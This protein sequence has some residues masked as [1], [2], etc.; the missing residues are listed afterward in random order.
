[1]GAVKTDLRH[2]HCVADVGG[3]AQKSLRDLYE[4]YEFA[5]RVEGAR[6]VLALGGDGF[7]LDV[8]HRYMSYGV[9]IYGMNCGTVGFLM[10]SYRL[11]RLDAALR[12]SEPV[13]LF[14]LRMRAVTT[15]GREYDA[16]AVN[17]VSLLRETRQ[18][19]HIRLS[20]DKRVRVQ[21]L[22][23]DGALICT[24]AGSTAYNLS[25]GGPI[26]PLGSG[27]LALTPLNPFRP[28]RWSGALIP[29]KATVELEVLDPAKRPVS[30]VADF[31]EIRDVARVEVACDEAHAVTLLFD[32]G[33]SLEE[34]IL[35]EQFL[36]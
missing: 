5:E 23:G 8:L 18:T 29:D 19:A 28:R 20:I 9:P 4:R 12:E 36:H 34:R 7:M 11:T 10:N 13:R 30:A 3:R 35:N 21:E 6:V 32:K 2:V 14:P 15:D 27:V 17:E 22:I 16:L 24:P 26:V 33:H 1:M 31:T 25:A